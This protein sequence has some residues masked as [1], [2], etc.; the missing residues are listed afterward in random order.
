MSAWAKPGVK[1]VCIDDGWSET[2]AEG[3][4]LPNRIPMI[5]EVLT[6]A[7]AVQKYGS[8]FLFF[9]EI[10]GGGFH[11]ECFRPLVQHTQEQDLEH[12]LPLLDSVEEAA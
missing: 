6:V 5:H 11:I 1:C 3:G 10:P 9:V 12:F 7:G 2:T 4:W 8:V